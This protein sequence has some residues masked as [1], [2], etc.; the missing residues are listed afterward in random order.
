MIQLEYTK[1]ITD[2]GLSKEQAIVYEVLL[3]Q[4]ESPA[5]SI[6]KAVPSG[7]TL[8]RP[9]VYKVLEELIQLDLA[10]KSD[11]AGKIAKFTPKHPVAITKVIDK[12]KERIEQTK[13]QFLA[14]SGKLSSLFNLSVGKPG[15][16]FYE[17]KDGVWEVLM[18]S[19]AA[20]EE[21]LTYADLEAIAKYIPDLNAEY[22]AIREDQDVK[23]R[24]LVID[25]PEA[26]KFLKS[27]DGEVTHTKLISG[28]ETTVP[29][30][31]IMQIYD[32]KVSYITLTDEY[33]VGIIITDQLI[34]NTHKYLFESMWECSSGE[35]V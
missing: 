16:Q 2:T 32:N 17:G 31:T 26:R 8:S 6:A 3:K 29:F 30:Q 35:V 14:T 5:S 24:G 27:Y 12:Q 20:S 1:E 13:K 25:S 15:V 23:K 34:A 11:E 9:L 22:S 28:A 4:G 18:D 10:T 33:L 19:L 21:I 7:T